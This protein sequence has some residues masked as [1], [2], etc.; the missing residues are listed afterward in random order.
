MLDVLII[1][2]GFAGICTAIKLREAGTTNF[3]IVEK[4][5]NVGGTWYANTYPGATCDVPS[6]FYS[7][8]FAPN[9]NWSRLYSPQPEILA[10]IEDCADQYGVRPHI[11]FE[12]EVTCLTFDQDGGFWTVDFKD[13][14]SVR[15][16]FVVNGMGGLHRPFRPD[17]AGL[18][19][20]DGPVMH[21]A[22]W[23]QGFDPAGKRVAVIGSAASAIQVVPKVAKVAQQVDLYQRTPNFIAPRGDF[24]YSDRQKW[25]FRR[26]P[27]WQRVYRWFIMQRMDWLLY[28]P[29]N[30]W[31]G[32]CTLLCTAPNDGHSCPTALAAIWA[33]LSKTRT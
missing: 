24:A 31:T 20:F 8:S 18:D 13:H 9:P 22:Q 19:Q 7:F 12:T 15:A 10:Y 23:D 1:G 16:R 3:R 33:R 5:K 17:I 11:E 21:T 28:P 25:L 29:C 32:C 27:V 30:A 26:F 6:H 14:P 2:S 4:H